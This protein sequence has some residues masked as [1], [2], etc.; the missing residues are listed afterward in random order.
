MRCGGS[1][2][3]NDPTDQALAADPIRSLQTH[4]ACFPECYA[5]RYAGMYTY[6]V[7]ASGLF[8]RQF[9]M[10]IPGS[11]WSSGLQLGDAWPV[12]SEIWRMLA[13]DQGDA[14]LPKTAIVWDLL[15]A[16]REAMASVHRVLF[17][18]GVDRCVVSTRQI[19]HGLLTQRRFA[20][21]ILPE[22]RFL[23]TPAI[24]AIE[25]ARQ[26]GTHVIRT[27]DTEPPQDPVLSVN[28]ELRQQREATWGNWDHMDLSQLVRTL[29]FPD[30]NK[31]TGLYLY[32]K[33]N[34][35]TALN[36]GEARSVTIDRITGTGPVCVIG[37]TGQVREIRRTARAVTV[38]MQPL[39][40][41][42]VK[43]TRCH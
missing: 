21:I 25:R 7:G 15:S 9:S 24:E 14:P 33:Q 2:Y 18:A 8:T 42:V 31:M 30:T 37:D 28:A 5:D 36:A 39:Q 19:E 35:L 40:A 16:N 34:G 22:V 26:H 32:R 4:S 43:R 27:G 12:F 3:T 6:L 13:A 10:M 17:A 41:V 23:T 1:L 38:W 29:G 20:H 11:T